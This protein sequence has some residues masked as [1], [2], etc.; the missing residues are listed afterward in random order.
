M[1]EGELRGTLT[2]GKVVLI[3]F[4][5]PARIE[6]GEGEKPKIDALTA[7]ATRLLVG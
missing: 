6:L 5:Y 1:T 4:D 7:G 3:D 2:A